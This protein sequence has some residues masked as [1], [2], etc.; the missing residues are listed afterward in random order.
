M[1]Q[2]KYKLSK[3]LI[4][5]I[6]VLL[7]VYISVSYGSGIISFFQ[8]NKWT[9]L[10][11]FIL[12]IVLISWL[13]PS[14]FKNHKQNLRR[15]WYF[16]FIIGIVLIISG[17]GFDQE[18]WQ[19]YALLAGMF[20]FV[21]LTIFLTPNIKKIGGA[22][23]EKINEV[24]NINEEMKKTIIQTKNKGKQFTSILNR[25]D[26]SLFKSLEWDIEEYCSSLTEF[27]SSYGDICNQNII[28]LN[29]EE[30]DEKL[31]DELGIMGLELSKSNKENLNKNNVVQLDNY[32][33]L[34][35]FNDL[36]FPVVILIKSNRDSILQIDFDHVI[37]LVLIHSWYKKSD[38]L[39]E[40]IEDSL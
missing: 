21:D 22:E 10:I 27:L 18:H 15:T 34:I 35:P 33:A 37:N 26:Y 12:V 38:S 40:T 30:K 11:C 24:E 16:L 25:I 8:S 9:L 5:P 1:E 23:I 6:S 7:F 31:W 17:I 29:V 4:I 28:A 3:L 20:I 2:E 32:T 36:V 19:K 39:T 14:Y 13:F